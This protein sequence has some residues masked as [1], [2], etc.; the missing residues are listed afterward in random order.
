VIFVIFGVKSS[1]PFGGVRHSVVKYV[2][3]AKQTHMIACS[4]LMGV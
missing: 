3:Y 2:S 1:A 4:R